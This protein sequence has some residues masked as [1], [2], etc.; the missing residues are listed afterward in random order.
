MSVSEALTLAF[1]TASFCIGL[2]IHYIFEW[3]F[4]LDF[5]RPENRRFRKLK[6]MKEKRETPLSNQGLSKEKRQALETMLIPLIQGEEKLLPPRM[7]RTFRTETEHQLRLL[8]NRGLRREFYFAGVSCPGKFVQWNDGGREWREMEMD[9]SVLERFVTTSGEIVREIYHNHAA[10]LFRQSRR[11]RHD[12]RQEKKRQYYEEA[13]VSCPSCGAEVTLNAEEVRCDY[14]G[15]VISHQFFDW[16]AESFDFYDKMGNTG[17]LLLIALG[18]WVF[19]FLVSGIGFYLYSVSK[20]LTLVVVVLAIA[21][22]IASLW[23]WDHKQVALKKKIVRYSES[24]LRTCINEALWQKEDKRDLLSFGVD[25]I[26]LKSVR[27]KDDRT[28]LTLQTTIS[29]TFLPETGKPVNR[30]ETVTL[31][32]ERAKH[33]ERVKNKGK[34]F[35]EKDCPSC[36]ANFTPDE[37]GNCSYCGYGLHV[38]NGKWKLSE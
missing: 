14:C 28:Y 9:A 36:G 6:K 25:Q 29:R 21:L 20:L 16:Q 11:I 33:P 7:D 19:I 26:K 13:L 30:K 8:K 3:D 23:F 10:M 1:F 32:M 12:D 18:L 2:L 34:I 38:Y 5:F 35:V 24:Y 27:H 4:I 15:A 22:P 17:I 31:R 37:D